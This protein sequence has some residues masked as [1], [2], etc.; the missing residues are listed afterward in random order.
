MNP[1]NWIMDICKFM[2]NLE[3]PKYIRTYTIYKN[4][5]N[6]PSSQKYGFV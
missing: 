3:M 5:G 4:I 6:I 2:T 1:Y